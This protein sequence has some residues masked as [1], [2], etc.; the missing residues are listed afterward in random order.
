ME[1]LKLIVLCV[2]VIFVVGSAT[3][4]FCYYIRAGRSSLENGGVDALGALTDYMR[5]WPN[6]FRGIGDIVNGMVFRRG[7]TAPPADP[8]AGQPEADA[9]APDPDDND[10]PG[11]DLAA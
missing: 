6:P 2:V 4:A 1:T 10:P 3:F 11:A 8:E 7:T 9:P 5:A